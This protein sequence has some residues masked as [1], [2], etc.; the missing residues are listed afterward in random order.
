VN[1]GGRPDSS[2]RDTA[3]PGSNLMRNG[4]TLNLGTTFVPTLLDEWGEPVSQGEWDLAVERVRRFHSAWSAEE[5]ALGGYRAA[6]IGSLVVLSSR[7]PPDI[8][9]LLLG[10]AIKV[11]GA[12]MGNI[13]AF[14]PA[15][16]LL[17]IRTH[18]GFERPFLDY[19][20]QVHDDKGRSACG[21]ALHSGQCVTVEDITESSVFSC[22]ESL[23]VMLE[24]GVRA[25]HSTP[26]ISPSGKLAG[27]LSIHYRKPHCPSRDELIL[28]GYVAGQIA[29]HI[30][31]AADCGGNTGIN[32]GL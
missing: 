19:F 11:S 24:A 29:C 27:M 6:L 18:R 17:K 21:A 2:P 1:Y 12:D 28:V 32:D 16:N 4:A 15:A 9:S 5:A 30:V 14:D 8:L 13:Q 22:R 31:G 25:V 23:E 7:T 3:L 26:L 10:Q 20:D